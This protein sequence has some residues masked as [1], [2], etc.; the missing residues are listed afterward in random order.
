M[1]LPE[2]RV[3]VIRQEVQGEMAC[4]PVLWLAWNRG[5]AS[6][7]S[8]SKVGGSIALMYGYDEKMSRT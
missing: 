2:L 1:R 6:Y 4:Q 5:M 7:Y 3:G 8:R